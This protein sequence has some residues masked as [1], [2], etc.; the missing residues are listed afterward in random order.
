[1]LEYPCKRNFTGSTC[2]KVHS[3]VIGESRACAEVTASPAA[4]NITVVISQYFG[5][6]IVPLLHS[7]RQ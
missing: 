5:R 2:V 4:I 1:M 6:W 7:T 3:T